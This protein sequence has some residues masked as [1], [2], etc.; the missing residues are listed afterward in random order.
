MNQGS[1]QL[2][3]GSRAQG[4]RPRRKAQATRFKLN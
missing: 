2:K 3:K 4:K 1:S